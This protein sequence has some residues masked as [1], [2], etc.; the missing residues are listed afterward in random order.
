MAVDH[1]SYWLGCMHGNG[2][3]VSV[4]SVGHGRTHTHS[5]K[6]AQRMTGVSLGFD[7]QGGSVSSPICVSLFFMTTGPRYENY[8]RKRVT[9]PAQT[10]KEPKKDRCPD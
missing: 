10:R 5:R 9:L 1:P 4:S 8:C 7:D 3:G 6:N 2:Q